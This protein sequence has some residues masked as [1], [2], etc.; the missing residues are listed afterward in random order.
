MVLCPSDKKNLLE[1][2]LNKIKTM[3]GDGEE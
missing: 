3:T 2:Y 1:A